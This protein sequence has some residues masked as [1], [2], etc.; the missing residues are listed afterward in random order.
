VNNEEKLYNEVITLTQ[1]VLSLKSQLAET[2]QKDKIQ[3]LIDDLRQQ[4]V[5]ERELL[6]IVKI[7]EKISQLEELIK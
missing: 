7:A 2:I 5:S 1:E 6:G 3:V 4:F